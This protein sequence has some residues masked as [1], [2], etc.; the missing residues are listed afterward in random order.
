MLDELKAEVL[1]ANCDLPRYGLVTFTWGNVSGID[2]DRGLVVIKASGVPYEGMTSDDLVVV[3]L[4]GVVVDGTRKPSSDTP[5]HI[6]L[7]RQY[8]E[9][10]GIVHTHST[11]ATSWAQAGRDIPAFGTT[12]AD[13][14]FGDVPCTRPLSNAE[15]NG[16]YEYETARVII[17]TFT[18]RD[19][20]PLATPGVVIC[21]HGPFS[22]GANAHDALHNA[23]VL[24][25]VARLAYNT[26]VLSPE[27]MPISR[28]L[29]TKHYQRKHGPK[30]YYGQ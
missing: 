20:A 30:A 2:H 7:Y 10:G 13:Y 9:I 12:H 28:A 29:L 19:L 24:E 1:S 25:E 16:A 23:V 11:W 26:Q 18:Q 22:W 15:I 17:E 8:A 6:E 4:E 14:F 5:T 21:E 27:K 3:D